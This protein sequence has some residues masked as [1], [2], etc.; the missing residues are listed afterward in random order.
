[1]R[2]RALSLAL[3]GLVA[4][5]A[6]LVYLLRGE[7]AP[8][9][10]L[11]ALRATTESA[12]PDLA[13][14]HSATRTS[15]AALVAEEPTAPESPRG[16]LQRIDGEVVGPLGQPIADAAI[17]LA[18]WPALEVTL[19]TTTSDG[20][21]RFA[22]AE[23]EPGGI[24]FVLAEAEGYT[25]GQGVARFRSGARETT[26][27]LR[28]WDSAVVSGR[29]LDPEGQPVAGA[30]VLAAN[31]FP[32]VDGGIRSP[33]TRTKEAGEF[34]LPGVPIGRYVLRVRAS[35]FAL[36]ERIGDSVHETSVEVR[37]ARDG[38]TRIE[39][40][41]RGLPPELGPQTVVNLY[42]MRQGHG[43]PLFASLERQ[44]FD[45]TGRLVIDGLYRD[46]EWHL[47]MPELE[48]WVFD[49]RE[50]S[51]PPG[52]EIHRV[53]YTAV[54]DG[55]IVLRGML[56]HVSGASIAGEQLVCYTQRSQSMSGDRPGQ[57]TTDA[58]GRFE[59]QAPLAP[60]EPY[61]LYLKS[62]RYALRQ[63]KTEK[64]SGASDPRYLVRFE[65]L[66]SDEPLQLV[67]IESASVSGKLLQL[68]D[69]P[70][71]F[72]WMELQVKRE[73]SSWFPLAYAV[74]GADGSFRFTAFH[75]PTVPH[76]IHTDDRG[77]E[78]A[79]ELH[80]TES[81]QLDDLIV[82]VAPSG[83]VGGSVRD[84]LGAPLVG[85]VVDL[86]ALEGE[87]K[88]GT[89]A[90]SVLSDRSGRFRFPSVSPGMKRLHLRKADRSSGGGSAELEVRSGQESVVDLQWTP[91]PARTR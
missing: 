81:E 24:L 86:V 45:R 40:E 3:L 10:S 57:A 66:A 9:P 48:G 85:A 32:W 83:S 21:G 68:D 39:V 60:N 25:P 79:L 23:V 82:R 69:Q 41:L 71:P 15:T 64:Q 18:K 52:T 49:P 44:H 75:A 76:R 38:G 50:H 62:S 42:G 8:A 33:E 53:T 17:R 7:P 90:G 12:R 58:D 26:V 37:L 89:V 80:L 11:L 30:E 5:I 87:T 14:T 16:P 77:N 70:A 74:S 20:R 36:A 46:V 84:E 47:Q 22:F 56:R 78:G 35:G 34:R 2:N 51:L 61:S 28:L 59:M 31:D 43:F 63:E 67:A 29:V 54:K 4:L 91:P 13:A 73:G 19:A 65:A 55:T 27:H 6:C 1:M 88:R 72:Q